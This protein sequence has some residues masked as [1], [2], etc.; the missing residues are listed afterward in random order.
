MP[1][2]SALL[3]GVW[4]IRRQDTLWGDEAVT[5]AVAHRTVSQIWHTLGHI[6]VV[7]GLYYLLMHGVFTLWDG[8]LVA[9]RLPSVL[10]VAA[11]AVGIARLGQRL[12]TTRAGLLAGLVFPLLPPVQRYAQEGRSYAL[13]CALVT[14]ASCLLVGALSRP[15]RRGWVAYGAVM[16]TACLLHELAALTLLAHGVTAFRAR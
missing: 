10:A 13:V 7:H 11:A 3:V 16:L 15:R 1:G 4:G 9:L 5:S 14:W 6:D 2:L 8:G 12:A